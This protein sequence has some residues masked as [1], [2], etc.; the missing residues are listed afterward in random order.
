ME[1]ACLVKPRHEE[2]P[3]SYELR[4]KVATLL[5]RQA[6]NELAKGLYSP[7][8]TRELKGGDQASYEGLCQASHLNSMLQE[9]DAM[10]WLHGVYSIQVCPTL[11]PAAPIRLDPWRADEFTVWLREDDPRQPWAVLVRSVFEMRRQVRYQ[12]W[13]DT[14]VRTY[15][16]QPGD[17]E[18]A[19]PGGRLLTMDQGLSGPHD[20]GCLPF[21]FFH[22]REPVCSFFTPGLGKP[23]AD[24]EAVL[25]LHASDLAQSVQCH[26]IPM[27]FAENVATMSRHLHRPGDLV[28]VVASNRDREAKIFQAQPSL[29][30]EEVWGHIDSYADRV[31]AALD[32]PLTVS[33]RERTYAESGVAL[34]VRRQPML[35]AWKARQPLFSAAEEK[36]AQVADRVA[37]RQDRTISLVVSFPE[38]RIPLPTPERNDADT[39]ELDQGL[40]SRVRLL[41]ERKGLTRAQALD[42]MRQTVEDL[43]EERDI[44]GEGPQEPPGQT[45]SNQPD[46]M[47]NPDDGSPDGTANDLEAAGL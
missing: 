28:D 44:Y 23:L 17:I 3:G 34:M 36:L 35:D 25:N 29:Q 6:I 30:V 15:W 4:P 24:A 19:A 22:N 38:P 10:T 45:Q 1:G 9:A 27:T 12:A 41:Q 5:T 11:D 37:T 26:C 20:L 13:T 8:P 7:G 47:M 39:W 18:E 16:S 46:P 32:L 31:L 14:E 40:T 42:W 33:P 21:V 2:D 43:K